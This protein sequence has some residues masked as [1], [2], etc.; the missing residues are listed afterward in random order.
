VQFHELETRVRVSLRDPDAVVYSQDLLMDLYNQAQDQFNKDTG[1]HIRIQGVHVP[2]LNDYTR[3]YEW[4]EE[5]GSG[6]MRRFGEHYGATGQFCTHEWE[7]AAIRGYTPQDDVSSYRVTHSW[8]IYQIEGAADWDYLKFPNDFDKAIMVAFDKRRLT[9]FSEKQLQQT[10]RAYK[11]NTGRV[12]GYCLVGQDQEREFALYP[13][14]N[15]YT[16]EAI[17]HEASD[18]DSGYCFDWESSNSHFTSD[19]RSSGKITDESNGYECIYRWEVPFIAGDTNPD[20]TFDFG[21]YY[22][23]NNYDVTVGA[24]TEGMIISVDADS[25]TTETGT[26]YRWDDD[27]VGD[28][29]GIMV[30][31]VSLD[32]NVLV[33]YYPRVTRVADPT[34]DIELWLDW[35]VKYIERL[36]ISLAF[37]CNNNRYNQEAS[38]FWKMRYQDGLSVISRYKAKRTADRRVALKSNS[39]RRAGQRRGLVDLPEDYPSAWE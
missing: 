35:Q 5:Y 10:S 29:Y 3:T 19:S 13:R 4:E 23:T 21:G 17:D 24:L 18:V 34:D 15:D 9:P 32:D 37:L 2:G 39:T 1:L 8:E 26:F 36:M 14:T 7:A 30:D 38:K 12:T 16:F 20:S 33:V 27:I 31:Y 6:A 11:T 22:A 25:T 28:S